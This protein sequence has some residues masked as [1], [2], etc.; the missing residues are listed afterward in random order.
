MTFGQC[1]FFFFD[2]SSVIWTLNSD[3]VGAF[4]VIVMWKLP[5]NTID[6]IRKASFFF[7][8]FIFSPRTMISLPFETFSVFPD[9]V[10]KV[11]ETFFDFILSFLFHIWILLLPFVKQ[12]QIF[13]ILDCG[14]TVM[15]YLSFQLLPRLPKPLMF[16]QWALSSLAI[17]GITHQGKEYCY[18]W[19]ALLYNYKY[20]FMS[21]SSLHHPIL[22]NVWNIWQVF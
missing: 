9:A 10:P 22:F 4:Y 3:N 21:I 7:Y 6:I 20:W 2:R 14:S 12:L 19:R 17:H 11:I 15:T 8:P 13:A 5:S 18:H 16:N 1:F